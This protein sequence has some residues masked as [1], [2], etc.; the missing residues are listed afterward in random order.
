MTR[1][2]ALGDSIT[3]GVGQPHGEHLGT[4]GPQPAHDVGE[5]RGQPL[6]VESRPERVVDPDHHAGDVRA[7]L[8]RPR[9]LVPLDVSHASA[10][11][12]ENV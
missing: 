2:A 10:V 9:Q 8:K 12:G 7:E 1:F 6:G 11:I 5:G 3:L 4:A